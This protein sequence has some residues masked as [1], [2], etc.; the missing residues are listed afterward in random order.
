MRRR[1]E[2]MEGEGGREKK[3][4]RKRERNRGVRR[5]KIWGDRY[6]VICGSAP[7]A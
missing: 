7:H 1:R 6:H 3:E 2:E 4:G 5:I